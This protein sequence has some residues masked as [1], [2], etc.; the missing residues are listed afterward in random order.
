MIKSLVAGQ[1][2]TSSQGTTTGPGT[3]DDVLISHEV[4]GLR[5]TNR[6]GDK[7]EKAG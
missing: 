1:R 2:E 7:S 4:S 6:G 3:D 5:Q